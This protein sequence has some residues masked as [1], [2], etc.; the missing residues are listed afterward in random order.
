MPVYQ[1]HGPRPVSPRELM[2]ALGTREDG[3]VET[4]PTS[5]GLSAVH[6]IRLNMEA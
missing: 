3:V 2:I 4:M 6:G 5:G 1:I